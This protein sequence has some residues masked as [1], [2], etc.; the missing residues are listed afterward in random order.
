MGICFFF[1]MNATLIDSHTLVSCAHLVRTTFC[2]MD[3]S[4]HQE[5]T[6]NLLCV[7]DD[8]QSS[9]FNSSD[10]GHMEGSTHWRIKTTLFVCL[11]S[12]EMYACD[13]V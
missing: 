6:L 7:H 1:H 11:Q 4:A 8:F 13:R 12:A 2:G 3:I 10:R 5:I 9:R